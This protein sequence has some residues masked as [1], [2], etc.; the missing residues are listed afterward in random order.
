M[1]QRPFSDLDDARKDHATL[2]ELIIHH[3]GGWA[4]RAALRKV[5]ESCR[6]AM[7]AMDDAECRQQIAIVVKYAADLFSEQAHRKWDRGQTRGA[8]FLRLEIMKALHAFNVRLAVIEAA[9]RAASARFD[10]SW[11]G[12]LR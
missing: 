7:S 5:V 4:D 9:R 3:Q 8:D 11:K 6:A 10:E 1:T 2:L 12:R